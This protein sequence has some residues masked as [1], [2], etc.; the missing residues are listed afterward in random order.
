MLDETLNVMTNRLNSYLNKRFNLEENIAVVNVPYDSSGNA[1]SEVNNKLVVFLANVSK[2]TVAQSGARA[3]QSFTSLQSNGPLYLNLNVIVG[4]YF[5]A[6]RYQEALHY[7]S[8]ALSCFQL[9]SVMDRN[10]EPDLP[11]GVDKIV[12]DIENTSLQ[13]SSNLWGIFGGKYIPSIL[14]KVRMVVVDDDAVSSRTFVTQDSETGVGSDSGYEAA[15]QQAKE[16]AEK[17]LKGI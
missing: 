11:D 10:S 2:D 9:H 6:Q 3:A 4:A 1:L 17:A 14:Y 5:T 15:K 13:E 8:C 7:L 16:A 12:L